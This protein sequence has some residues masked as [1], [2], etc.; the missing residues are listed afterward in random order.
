MKIYTLTLNPAYDVH[1]VSDNFAPYRESLA[2]IQS[3][4]AGGKGVNISRA[5]CVGQIPHR[6]V[7]VLGTENGGDFK[8]DLAKTGMDCIFLEKEGRI[9]E[10]LTLHCAGVP[11]TR[12]SFAGFSVDDGILAEVQD[13]MEVDADTVITLTG[14]LP[15]G[16]S[17]TAAMAFLRQLQE[18][19]GRIV[20]DSKSFSAEEILQLQP[21]LIKPNQEEISEY[22]RCTVNTPAEA[23]E[24]AAVFAGHGVANVM[25]SL[26]EQGALLLA[27]G[28]TWLASPPAV[29]ALSTVG[30]GDSTIAGFLAAA[31]RGE[32]PAACLQTAVA[33]GTAACLTPGTLPPRKEDIET[34]LKQITVKEVL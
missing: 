6:A 32:T 17:K 10:N 16:V 30:A 24:K 9:R 26:G 1:A 31:S 33:Y 11:E 34:I 8:A 21:W 5:L 3:R 25:V 20:L 7:I 29:E 14:R 4:E 19:G 18:K 23:A 13:A 15:A 28:K 2:Q 22:L 27:D 12:I